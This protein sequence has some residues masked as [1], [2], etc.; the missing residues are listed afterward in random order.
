MEFREIL[1][2]KRETITTD[3]QIIEE[4]EDFNVLG[5]LVLHIQEMD[6]C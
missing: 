4:M 1:P 5:F 2:I 6:I 3:E